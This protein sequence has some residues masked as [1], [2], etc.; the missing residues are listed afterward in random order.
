MFVLRSMPDYGFDL[1]VE[2]VG[3]GFVLAL[4]VM[5]LKR[6]KSKHFVR[7]KCAIRST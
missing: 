1:G 2:G 5:L 6:T 7:L 4:V 3:G